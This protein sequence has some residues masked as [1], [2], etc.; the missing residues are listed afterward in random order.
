M[1]HAT[2]VVTNWNTANGYKFQSREI[3]CNTPLGPMTV[4]TEEQ[5]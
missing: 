1:I 5:I 3:R 2:L 4:K